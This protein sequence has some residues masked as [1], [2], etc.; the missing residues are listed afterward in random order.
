MEALP[1]PRTWTDALNQAEALITRMDA[2]AA[3]RARR[4]GDD[5]AS[6]PGAPPDFREDTHLNEERGGLRTGALSK[7]E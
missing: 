3:R 7:Q 1:M 4:D 6:A 2:F 5:P